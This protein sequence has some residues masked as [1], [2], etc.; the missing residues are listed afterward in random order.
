MTRKPKIELTRATELA[1]IDAE[2]DDALA[3][4]E[5]TSSKV[6]EILATESG[7]TPSSVTANSSEQPSDGD[8]ESGGPGE[9]D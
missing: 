1:D 7:T 2:L 4:L 8:N 5:A 9:V 6:D 3:K